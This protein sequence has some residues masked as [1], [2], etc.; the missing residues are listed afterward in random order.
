[1]QSSG[2][3]SNDG[4]CNLLRRLL[5]RRRLRAPLLSLAGNRASLMN[6]RE[7]LWRLAAAA[8]SGALGLVVLLGMGTL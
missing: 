7:A 8:L 4:L 1:M 5:F 3:T 2:V 6:R